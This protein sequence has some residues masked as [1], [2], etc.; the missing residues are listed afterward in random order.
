MQVIVFIDVVLGVKKAATG[1][2]RVFQ[3]LVAKNC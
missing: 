3:R 1:W 2:L